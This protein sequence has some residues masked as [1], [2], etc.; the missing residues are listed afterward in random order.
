MGAL[1]DVLTACE[2]CGHRFEVAGTAAGSLQNCPSCGKATRVA[3]DF[4]PTWTA[5]KFIVLAMCAVAGAVAFAVAGPLAGLAVG[6]GLLALAFVLR[7]AL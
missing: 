7:T 5:F 6:G 3:G 4:D 2:H 1:R